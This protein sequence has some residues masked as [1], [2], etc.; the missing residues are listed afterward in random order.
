MKLVKQILALFGVE[1]EE[2]A[3]LLSGGSALNYSTEEGE[4][5]RGKRVKKKQTSVKS[6][7]Q[8]RRLAAER[9][10]GEGWPIEVINEEGCLYFYIYISLFFI[11]LA[12]KAVEVFCLLQLHGEMDWYVLVCSVTHNLF[13]LAIVTF[14]GNG[15]V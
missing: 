13:L 1:S 10:V 5:R 8:A 4:V 14:R 11:H 12:V 15:P 9:Q 7:R 2:N 3:S 6:S